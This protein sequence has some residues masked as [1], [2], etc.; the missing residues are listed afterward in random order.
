[1]TLF[2]CTAVENSWYC[3]IEA[4]KHCKCS[5][6]FI[7]KSVMNLNKFPLFA[8]CASYPQLFPTSPYPK[9]HQCLQSNPKNICP[10]R[11]KSTPSRQYLRRLLNIRAPVGSIWNCCKWLNFLFNANSVSTYKNY[12]LSTHIVAVMF[13]LSII[14]D[15]LF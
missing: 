3:S 4:K 6:H 11:R 5:Y 2:V 10:Y 13:I 7:G 8:C 15:V 12:G 14:D 9:H 1:M